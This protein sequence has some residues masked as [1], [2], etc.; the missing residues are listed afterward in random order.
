MESLIKVLKTDY[1]SNG[2][3]DEIKYSIE[4]NS[5]ICENCE[6]GKI[7]IKYSGNLKDYS[8]T[9]IINNDTI[10][11]NVKNGVYVASYEQIEDEEKGLVSKVV[12]SKKN[13]KS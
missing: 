4:N 8:G 9:V 1:Q 7:N 11:M 6:E 2:R 12:I 5:V 3:I 13:S 10:T